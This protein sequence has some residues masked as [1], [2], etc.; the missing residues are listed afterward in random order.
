MNM[1]KEMIRGDTMARN[2]RMESRAQKRLIVVVA[3][4]SYYHIQY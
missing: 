3:N 2:V 1:D 4:I